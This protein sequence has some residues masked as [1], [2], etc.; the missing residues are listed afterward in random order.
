MTEKLFLNDS[1]QKTVMARV[2][3]CAAAEGGY[4][5]ELDRTVLFPAG[6]GQ[7]HDTGRIGGVPVTGV[8]EDGERVLHRTATPLP[9]GAEV[10]VTLDW[11]R[12]FDHMQQHSGEHLLSFAAKELFGAKNVGFHMAAAYCTVDLDVPLAPG[13]AARLEERTNALVWQNL[14]VELSYVTPEQLETMELRKKAAGLSGRIRIVAMPGGDSC[15]CCGTHVGHTGEIGLVKITASEHY[16]G[17]ERLTFACG[18]R[19]LAHA[20]AMQETVDTLARGFSCKAEDVPEAVAKLQQEASALRRDNKALLDRLS[21]YMARELLSGAKTAGGRKLIVRLVDI[22]AAQLRALALRVCEGGGALAL[23][24]APENGQLSYA[25]ACSED[26]KWNMGELAP[27]VNAALS[28]R[29]GG[30]GTLAQGSAKDT[31]AARAAAEALET[32]LLQ[33]LKGEK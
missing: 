20:Q 29:G 31:P 7:P 1:Y 26:V 18:G 24:L 16:K 28:G 19:A 8:V 10:E 13:G 21:A 12:R 2:T 33:R 5:V 27:A 11:P 4:D 23:L 3:A 25:L 22:P 30:R 9:V 15:T 14:P 32:Y 17:G 6:G